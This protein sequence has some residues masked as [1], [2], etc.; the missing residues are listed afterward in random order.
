MQVRGAVG[1]AT[2]EW[3]YSVSNRAHVAPGYLDKLLNIK[4]ITSNFE[5]VLCSA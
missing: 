4:R 5:L 2:K 3:T 1:L